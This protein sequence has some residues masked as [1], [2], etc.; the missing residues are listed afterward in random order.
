MNDLNFESWCDGAA[1]G[2]LRRMY[3][4]IYIKD[5]FGRLSL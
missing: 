4:R 3:S 2:R 1:R 5:I